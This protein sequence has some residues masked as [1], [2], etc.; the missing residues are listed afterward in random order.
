VVEK[1]FAI[2]DFP[3]SA[4]HEAKRLRKSILKEKMIEG[5]DSNA[6]EDQNAENER[7]KSQRILTSRL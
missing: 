6:T 1:Q 2:C 3:K 7:T 5:N 4:S